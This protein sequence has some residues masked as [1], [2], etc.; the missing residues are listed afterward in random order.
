M[1]NRPRSI[2]VRKYARR[3]MLSNSSKHAIYG[4]AYMNDSGRIIEE[5]AETPKDIQYFYT[6]DSFNACVCT[7]YERYSSA[8]EINVYAVHRKDCISLSQ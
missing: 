8:K 7:L 4:I 5:L 6:D 1:I 2:Q 3:E